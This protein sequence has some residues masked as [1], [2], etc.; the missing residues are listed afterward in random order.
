M[1][2]WCILGE[3]EQRG[4]LWYDVSVR[5]SENVVVRLGIS[6]GPPQPLLAVSAY[7]QKKRQ[8]YL[9]KIAVMLRQPNGAQHGR[10][11]RDPSEFDDIMTYQQIHYLTDCI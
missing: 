1:F 3:V 11:N 7:I 9:Q 6:E 4:T 8:G 2:A 10:P 5:L